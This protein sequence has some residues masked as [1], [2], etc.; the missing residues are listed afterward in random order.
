A[1]E[2]LAVLAERDVL[3]PACRLRHLREE[4]LVRALREVPGIAFVAGGRPV[5]TA[6]RPYLKDLDETDPAWDLLDWDDYVFYARPGARLAIVSS[7]RGCSEN[8]AFCSQQKFW[9]QS[10]RGRSP[11][12]FVGEIEMLHKEYGVSIFFVSDEYPT[13]DRLRWERILRLLMRARLPVWLLIETCVGDVI[14]DA[15]ILSLYRE[16]GIVHMYVG[17]EATSQET[18]DFFKK[19][20]KAGQGREAL[21]L[22]NEAGIVTETSFILGLP[23]ESRE[24]IKRTLALAKEYDPDFAHFLLLAPWPYSDIWPETSPYVATLDYSK[25]NLVEPVIEPEQMSREELLAAVIDCYRTFYRDKL[26][27]WDGLRDTF[28]RKYCFDS[29]KAVIDHSFLKEHHGGLGDM[30]SEVEKYL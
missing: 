10:W 20:A 17:V 29:I 1:V 24:S 18:L 14:R 19:N 9:K 13:K 7:S 30:P 2:L 26:P 11:E 5:A 3:G 6:D 22:L 23:G 28:K 25:Y 8:C 16:A 15:D 12:A 21:R 4:S 27:T